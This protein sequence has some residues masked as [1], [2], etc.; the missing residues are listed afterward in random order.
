MAGQSDKYSHRQMCNLLRYT[1][2]STQFIQK[3]KVNTFSLVV[4]ATV[5][6]TTT[7][8]F[9]KLVD[10]IISTIYNF[11]TVGPPT[12][13]VIPA[14]ITNCTIDFPFAESWVATKHP[15]RG[16]CST[17]TMTYTRSSNFYSSLTSKPVP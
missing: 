11:N 16:S 3:I 9:A 7:R 15:S 5:S 2:T 1:I 6:V 10:K 4:R 12:T 13:I 14:S 8:W 17:I